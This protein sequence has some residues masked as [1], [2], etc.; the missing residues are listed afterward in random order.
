[1]LDVGAVAV[2]KQYQKKYLKNLRLGAV[3]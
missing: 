1:M 2:F 3:A